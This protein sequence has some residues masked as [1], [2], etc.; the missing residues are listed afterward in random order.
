MLQPRTCSPP[1]DVLQP[2]SPRT[3][4]NV[5]VVGGGTSVNS[6]P[7]Q[8]YMLV[9]M[10]SESPDELKKVDDAFQRVVPAFGG[11]RQRCRLRDG[12]PAALVL[13]HVLVPAQQQPVERGGGVIGAGQRFAQARLKRGQRTRSHRDFRISVGRH[14]QR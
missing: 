9:D 12:D 11:N 3:T 10:R 8:M 6:I 14:A 1:S 7:T 13:A 4:F 5:G 2:A